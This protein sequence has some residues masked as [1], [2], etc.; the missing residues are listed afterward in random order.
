MPRR[1]PARY[2]SWARVRASTSALGAPPPGWEGSALV[3]AEARSTM[4]RRG[5]SI[6]MG[7]ILPGAEVGCVMAASTPCKISGGVLDA[8][9][10]APHRLDEIGQELGAKLLHVR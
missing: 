1:S 7:R 4:T 2:A 10:D 9:A 8:I 6:L 5:F 3:H